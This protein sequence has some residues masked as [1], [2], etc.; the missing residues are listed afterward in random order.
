[1]NFQLHSNQEVRRQ[2]EKKLSNKKRNKKQEHRNQK[3]MTKKTG[4]AVCMCYLIIHR[5]WPDNI[6]M[7]IT[8]LPNGNYS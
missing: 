1:M 2:K 8:Q 5:P 3:N 4:A 6:K 7:N